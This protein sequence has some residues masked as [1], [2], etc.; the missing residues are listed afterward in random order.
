MQ[1]TNQIVIGGT[2]FV[3]PALEGVVIEAWEGRVRIRVAECA[4]PHGPDNPRRVEIVF[5]GVIETRT[6]RAD[7]QLQ[8]EEIWD[9]AEEEATA[10]V[11]RIE[12]GN[13]RLVNTAFR[14]DLGFT[15]AA[16][17][18]RTPRLASVASD[19]F[20][21]EFLYGGNVTHREP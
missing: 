6:F 4:P 19:G 8:Q 15:W 5:E 17:A 16:T 10:E 2:E 12:T 9:A 1:V 14:T 11:E 7:P 20:Y 13:V 18:W 21:M 3:D